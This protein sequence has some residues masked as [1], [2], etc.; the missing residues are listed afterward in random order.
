MTDTQATADSY[1][2]LVLANSV[3]VFTFAFGFGWTYIVM[4]VAQVLA[5]LRLDM[6]SWGMLWSAISFGTLVSAMIGGALG[7]RYGVQKIVGLGVAL[8][9]VTLVIAGHGLRFSSMYVWMFLFGSPS[10]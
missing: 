4:V 8:M 7:D 5:D 10:P 2:W 1:R 6:A 3:L 9:G